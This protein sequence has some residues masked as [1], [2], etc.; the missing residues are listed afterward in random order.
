MSTEEEEFDPQ[1]ALGTLQRLEARVQYERDN[2]SLLTEMLVIYTKLDRINKAEQCAF[3]ALRVFQESPMSS[4]QGLAAV[5]GALAC[6]KAMK[7]TKKDSMRLNLSEERK[8]LLE[9]I[10]GSLLELGKLRDGNLSQ[11]INF[12]FAYVKECLGQFQDALS[13]LSDLITAQASNGVELSFIILRAAVLLKHLSGNAQSLEYLEYLVDDPPREEGYKKTHILAM[14]VMVYEQSGERY[15]VSLQRTY[16]EL[17]TSYLEDMSS[18]R[19]AQTNKRKIE[20]MLAETPIRS[21]SAI[22]EQLAL[23]AVDRCEY[24]MASEFMQMAMLKAPNKSRLL[25]LAGEIYCII[26]ETE[27]AASCAERAFVLQPQSNELRN[28]LLI[29]APQ[30][31]RGKLRSVPTTGQSAIVK[32]EFAKKEKAREEEEQENEKN[33]SKIQ[34]RGG[35]DDDE[36]DPLAATLAK[37]D[38]LKKKFTSGATNFFLGTPE[39]RAA[40]EAKAKDKKIKEALAK[41]EREKREKMAAAAE[42]DG[43]PRNYIDRNDG[44]AN[45]V[46]PEETDAS[47]KVLDFVVQGNE[48]IHLYDKVLMD[49]ARVKAMIAVEEQEKNMQSAHE[50]NENAKGKKKKKKKRGEK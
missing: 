7:Y 26:G 4:S 27:R 45:P 35:D 40:K 30:K 39:Q 32:E 10:K 22:W 29:V 41:A 47:M 8:N 14:L 42:G 3:E 9:E 6:W 33:L 17:K 38:M 11:R 2:L 28:L 46:P 44:P 34:K 5:E 15:A 12:I 43:K 13:L 49:L 37:A 50:E 1:K 24:I 19:K 21:N 16:D 18:G 23:Q 36:V 31:W 20:K 48:N 25:H